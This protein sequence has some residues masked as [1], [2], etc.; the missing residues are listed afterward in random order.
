MKS[1][2]IV[3]LAT[4]LLVGSGV[5]SVPAAAQTVTV[6][7]PEFTLAKLTLPRLE[8]NE[9]GCLYF[10]WTTLGT[11]LQRI[12]FNYA[13]DSTGKIGND[14]PPVDNVKIIIDPMKVVPTAVIIGMDDSRRSK[15]HLMMS[16]EVYNTNKQ[17]L[18]GVE[19][20]K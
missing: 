19:I 13:M 6:V 16:Q 9:R 3:L 8:K 4:A 18:D 7:G 15:W 1:H 17:C 5:M 11:S 2:F 14:V 20:I 10:F 12:S